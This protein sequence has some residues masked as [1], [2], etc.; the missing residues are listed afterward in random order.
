L[1]S[2]YDFYRVSDQA[3]DPLCALARRLKLGDFI[4][5]LRD[6]Y[7]HL[8]HAPQLN[9]IANQGK[10]IPIAG[11]LSRGVSLIAKIAILGTTE[12]LLES[13]ASAEFRLRP[14]VGKLDFSYMSQN[15]SRNRPRTP[16]HE[17]L[18]EAC[19]PGFYEEIRQALQLDAELH[20]HATTEVQRRLGAVSNR[21]KRLEDFRARCRRHERNAEMIIAASNHPH[22]FL[23]F[24]G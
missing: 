21:Q 13:L 22:D 18:R 3:G 6:E 20:R 19:G 15:V 10:A 23:R 16:A 11:D 12:L 2:I 4:R 1:C 14:E 9:F 7:P 17:R 8:V 24:L 5:A